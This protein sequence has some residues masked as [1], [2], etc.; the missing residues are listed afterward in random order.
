M[1]LAGAADPIRFGAPRVLPE[2]A[3]DGPV[4]AVVVPDGPV[5]RTPGAVSVASGQR[6]ELHDVGRATVRRLRRLET[7]LGALVGLIALIGLAPGIALVTRRAGNVF[8]LLEV[9]GFRRSMRRGFLLSI[10][11]TASVLAS[12]LGGA[13]AL[14]VSAVMNAG[15][16]SAAG[17]V[18][19]AVLPATAE[20]L[21]GTVI[22]SAAQ[23]AV[24]TPSVG[25]FAVVVAAATLLGV[26]GALPSLRFADRLGSRSILWQW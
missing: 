18:P 16:R 13:A 15:G 26:V 4:L 9:W 22:A 17:L 8:G 1:L 25:S 23:S 6:P 11:A 2:S 24:V 19:A 5:N 10:A 20:D 21:I 14:V 7:A 12:A 3:G